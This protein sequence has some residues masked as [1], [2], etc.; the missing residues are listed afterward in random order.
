MAKST[1]LLTDSLPGPGRPGP[2]LTSLGVLV[3]LVVLALLL[4]FTRQPTEIF[5]AGL[6]PPLHE[7][8]REGRLGAWAGGRDVVIL[9]SQGAIAA[10]A[11]L[12][13]FE[14]AQWSCAWLNLVE[15]ELGPASVCDVDSASAAQVA[16][17]R[18]LIVTRSAASR[19]PGHEV[20]AAAEQVARRGGVV[21]L[22]VPGPG[23]QGL[24]GVLLGEEPR[25][26]SP[27]VFRGRPLKYDWFPASLSGRRPREGSWLS[28]LAEMP[29]Q[30]WTYEILLMDPQAEPAGSLDGQPLLVTR[31]LGPGRVLSLAFDLGFQLQAL[32][33][34]MPHGPGWV[35]EEVQGVFPGVV[36]TQDLVCA[37]QMLDNPLPYA[38]MLEAWMVGLLQEAAGPLPGWWRFPE[39]RPGALI[40]THLDAEG[41]EGRAL[42]RLEREQGVAPTVFRPG[43]QAGEGCWRPAHAELGLLWER[44]FLGLPGRWLPT[45]LPLARQLAGQRTCRLARADWGRDYARPFRIMAAAGIRL[46]SSYGPSAGRGYLFGTGLP[47]RA[48]NSDGLPL[49]IY[50]WPWLAALPSVPGPCLE[51]LRRDSL[52]ALHQ[53]LVLQASA[54]SEARVAEI[55]EQSREEGLWLPTLREGLAF[56]GARLQSPLSS[57]WQAGLLHLRCRPAGRGL[58][59]LV[60]ERWGPLRLVA[61]VGP[62]GPLPRRRLQ[63]LDRECV[64][65]EPPA[66]DS[67]IEVRY[68]TLEDGTR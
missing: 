33:Q 48:L 49:D 23:W 35:V 44:S 6:L 16:G 40:L 30:T 47:Y 34:G 22:E 56:Y 10:A 29:G 25:N 4:P 11:Q 66:G 61:A 17:A 5:L 24:S 68:E 46:D 19:S 62:E 12:Q 32:Q 21:L 65:L 3:G 67:A 13:S 14:A 8:Q 27:G 60:P 51:R 1:V 26:V 41:Q 20:V 58:W 38:D 57:T 45:R 59:L 53:A 39:A 54:G 55:L 37:Q 63:I 15:Q 2:L 64:L 31:P 50:E 9:L 36:E 43:P 28:R 42:A 52:E 7:E 18:V